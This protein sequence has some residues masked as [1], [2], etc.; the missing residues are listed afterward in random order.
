ML[1]RGDELGARVLL[2]SLLA[3]QARRTLAPSLVPVGGG[4]S[5]VVGGGAD[6]DEGDE[7][8]DEHEDVHD[9][10]SAMGE[11]ELRAVAEEEKEVLRAI[12]TDCL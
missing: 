1:A 2:L 9:D 5:V 6:E 7:D 11:E 4:A 12:A 8:E 3:R 10:A